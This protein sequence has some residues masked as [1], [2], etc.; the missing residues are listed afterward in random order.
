MKVKIKIFKNENEIMMNYS[1]TFTYSF[2]SLSV[3]LNSFS[4]LV[5]R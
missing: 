5:I 1:P 4:E 3:H 2:S